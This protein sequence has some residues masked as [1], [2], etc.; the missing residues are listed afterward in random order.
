M[1]RSSLRN[2]VTK[3]KKKKEIVTKTKKKKITLTRLV[4][5]LEHTASQKG[6]T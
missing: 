1:S 2:Y 4:K 3:K 5:M 6:T